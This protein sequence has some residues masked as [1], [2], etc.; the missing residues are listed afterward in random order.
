M[1]KLGL[2]GKDISH[3]QSQIMY[4]E[5]LGESVD[6]RLFDYQDPVEIPSLDWFFENIEGLSIT[7]PYKKHFLDQVSLIEDFDSINC[8]KYKNGNFLATNTDY[9]AIEEIFPRLLKL[10]EYEVIYVLGDGAMASLTKKY[11]DSH[12]L[13]YLQLSRKKNGSLEEF[14]FLNKALIINTCSRNFIYRGSVNSSM[15]FFD[16]NYNFGPH[17]EYLGPLVFKYF[18]GLELLKLQAKHALNFWGLSH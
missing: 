2:L 12:A 18:D 16:F 10:K 7:S 11:F 13:K 17:K 3:S 1:L 15:V 6:Y 8:I 4:E 14:E 5:L 9:K